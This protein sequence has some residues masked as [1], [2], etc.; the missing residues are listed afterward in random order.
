MTDPSRRAVTAPS[1]KGPFVDQQ[2]G[3]IC[4]PVLA[5][6][7]PDCPGAGDGGTPFQFI[8]PDPAIVLKADGSLGY[9][10]SRAA[11]AG[12]GAGGCP[13]C[14]KLPVTSPAEQQRRTIEFVKPYTLPDTA[15]RLEQLDAERKRLAGK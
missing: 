2:T 1:G 5:C 9:D 8:A 6:H 10:Q 15:R 4:W 13:Q 7:A 11:A 14:A 12:A 3:E